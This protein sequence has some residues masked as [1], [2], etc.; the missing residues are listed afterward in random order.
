MTSDPTRS[1]TSDTSDLSSPPR[2]RLDWGG[3]GLV[4]YMLLPYINFYK[5]HLSSIFEYKA[6]MSMPE[7]FA[8]P[9]SSH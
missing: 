8:I 7:F 5:V 1:N 4:G 6:D 9:S 2:L 3:V